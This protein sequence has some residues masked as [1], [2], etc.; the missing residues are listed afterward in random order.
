MLLCLYRVCSNST[1][2]LIGL[3][4][5]FKVYSEKLVRVVCVASSPRYRPMKYRCPC[6]V[7]NHVCTSVAACSCVFGTVDGS[8]WLV[9][10]HCTA[11]LDS[12]ISCLL[13]WH[14]PPRLSCEFVCIS[15]WVTSAKQWLCMLGTKW[16]ILSL[17][18]VQQ[19]EMAGWLS[20]CI[21]NVFLIGEFCT[22]ARLLP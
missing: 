15:E 3:V 1:D 20:G 17:H 22:T 12:S 6:K 18:T 14:A 8:T 11:L 9:W 4:G 2:K 7:C 21:R 10:P 5:G 19:T 13:A 16:Q